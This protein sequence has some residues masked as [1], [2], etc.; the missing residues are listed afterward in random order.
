MISFDGATLDCYR[1]REEQESFKDWKNL[2][3]R[4]FVQFRSRREGSICGRLL[5][6]KQE[7]IV[8]EYR[9]LFGKLL[10]SIA[11]VIKRSVRRNIYEG[12]DTV[13][14]GRSRVLG[15]HWA[16]AN[17]ETGPKSRES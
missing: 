9:N 16:S 6:I 10:C 3:E 7:S 8:E 2:K 11:A 5:S 17:D 13:D 4:L 15:A 12:A 14:K 1:A